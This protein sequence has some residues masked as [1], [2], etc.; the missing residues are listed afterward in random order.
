MATK[1]NFG[2]YQ[3]LGNDFVM[4]DGRSGKP[5]LSEKAIR[6]IADRR[7][8]VGCDQLMIVRK[9]KKTDY[10][11]ELYN[12]DGS[13]AEMCG[14]GI[15]CFARFLVERNITKKKKLAVETLAGI[16][17]TTLLSTQMVEVDM[18]EPILDG[19][20]VPVSLEGGVV[21]RRIETEMGTF[22]ITAV[23]MG[24]PHIM[25][26]TDN[27]DGIDLEKVGPYLE[28]HPLFPKRT[29]VHFVRVDDAKNLT[30]RHW[31][32]GAGATLACGTGAC[33]T[34]VAAILND[35]SGRSVSVH[36]R[37]GTMKIRWDKKDNRVYMT[38]PADHVFS[39][40]ITI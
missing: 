7:Y 17:R 1:I 15:R 30:V 33:A 13:V 19:P 26:F 8:G 6:H 37:G 32:R 12:A 22:N 39:G 27:L 9:S 5:A 25:I 35:L 11:M 16:I 14:N 24:N 40:V 36:Q 10:K 31:E 20:K 28:H 38:G 29:N 21:N 4:I 23:S 2:K 18:G 3:G 34:A